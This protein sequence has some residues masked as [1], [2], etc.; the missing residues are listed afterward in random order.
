[1]FENTAYPRCS[2]NKNLTLITE[3]HYK[4]FNVYK[5]KGPLVKE[6]MDATLQTI[7]KAMDQYPRLTAIR[8]DLRFPDYLPHLDDEYSNRVLQRFIESLKAKIEHDRYMSQKKYGSSH[9]TTVRYTWCR[10]Y[11]E[12]G[13]PHY[14]FNVLLNGNAYRNLGYIGSEQANM[15]KRI[16]SAWCSALGIPY[17][18]GIGLVYFPKNAVYYMGDDPAQLNQYIYRASYL[19]KVNS[20]HFGNGMHPFGHSRI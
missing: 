4:G 15:A 20:K 14:H 12:F 10:E 16:T 8:F 18:S 11:G 17:E 1:M 13:K 2:D 5:K 9:K 7:F 3:N 19:C 6:W